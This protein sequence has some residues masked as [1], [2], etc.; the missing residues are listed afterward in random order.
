MSSVTFS[1]PVRSGTY[2]RGQFFNA[3]NMTSTQSWVLDVV[4][5]TLTAPSGVVTAVT[6]AAGSF[7]SIMYVPAGCHIHDVLVD[8]HVAYNQGTSAAATIGSTVGGAEYVSSTSL[9]ATGR[10]AVTFSAAQLIAGYL[11]AQTVA[12]LAGNST[13]ITS[14]NLRVTSVGTNA[15]TGKAVITVRYA[16]L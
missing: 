16:Q 3:G 12:V 9:A 7:D 11:T 2:R 13:P 10:I 5:L 6:L 15:S 4:A 14:L 1:G 8:V